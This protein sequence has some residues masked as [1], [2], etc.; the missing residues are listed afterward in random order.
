MKILPGLPKEAESKSGFK[1]TKDLAISQQNVFRGARNP[2]TS[3][4]GT[5]TCKVILGL[6]K[7]P[8]LLSSISPQRMFFI[9]LAISMA[10]TAA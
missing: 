9:R 10:V 6:K 2:A 1:V 7:K 5:L 8:R 4:D 3:E